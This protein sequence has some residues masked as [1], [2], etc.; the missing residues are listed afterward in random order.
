MARSASHILGFRVLPGNRNFHFAADRRKG[1]ER[2]SRADDLA[3]Y[4]RRHRRLRQSRWRVCGRAGM[5]GG[6][7]VVLARP[8]GLGISRSR[9]TVADPADHWTFALGFHLVSRPKR[10]AVRS[11]TTASNTNMYATTTV[12]R[13]PAGYRFCSNLVRKKSSTDCT[14]SSTGSLVSRSSRCVEEISSNGSYAAFCA[15]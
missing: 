15:T 13:P 4:C 3:S 14:S 9:K 2:S 7:V 8:S 5:A 6:R 1:T 12:P 10:S 11:C